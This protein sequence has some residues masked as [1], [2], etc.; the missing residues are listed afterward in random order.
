M[1]IQGSVDS[2]TFDKIATGEELVVLAQCNEIVLTDDL[3]ES[4]SIEIKLIENLT[5]EE[6]DILTEVFPEKPWNADLPIFRI[7]FGKILQKTEIVPRCRINKCKDE[8]DLMD[9]LFGKNHWPKI[10]AYCE[11]LISE[12]VVMNPEETS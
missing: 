7:T 8:R 10:C 9:K 4:M 3:G 11:H 1:K 5:P 12:K 6:L 2:K